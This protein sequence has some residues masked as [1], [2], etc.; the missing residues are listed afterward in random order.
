MRRRYDVKYTYVSVVSQVR[1]YARYSCYWK[2][3]KGSRRQG[4]VVAYLNEWQRLA[5]CRLSCCSWLSA[6]ASEL[7][8]VG[9]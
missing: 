6:E 3:I 1:V 4:P 7:L 5:I 2:G 8:G 9:T